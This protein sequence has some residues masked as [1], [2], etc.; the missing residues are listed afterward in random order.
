M[1]TA[2]LL[3]YA[4]LANMIG[5]IA[6]AAMV[7]AN[8]KGREEGVRTS[9]IADIHKAL[10]Q[11]RDMLSVR[12]T[13]EMVQLKIENLDLKLRLEIKAA[14]TT[15]ADTMAKV[16]GVASAARLKS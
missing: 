4:Q 16:T 6:I 12:P 13:V 10:H 9:D 14:E 11:L 1:T 7:Y 3:V 5:L 8:R 2:D 15:L